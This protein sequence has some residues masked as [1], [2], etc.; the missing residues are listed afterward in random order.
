MCHMFEA[1]LWFVQTVSALMTSPRILIARRSANRRLPQKIITPPMA[2]P[3]AS[4]R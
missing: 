2:M 3:P 1:I 4:A